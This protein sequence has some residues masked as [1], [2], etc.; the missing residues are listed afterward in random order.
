MRPPNRPDASAK[1][2]VHG[3]SERFIIEIVI[4]Q[5][6]QMFRPAS[7]KCRPCYSPAVSFGRNERHCDILNFFLQCFT[8]FYCEVVVSRNILNTRHPGLRCMREATWSS[9][10]DPWPWAASS[11][12]M[13]TSS[14]LDS[15]H[16]F[17]VVE[18]GWT[19]YLVEHFWM[20]WSVKPAVVGILIWFDDRILSVSQNR[21]GLTW[22]NPEWFMEWTW[23]LQMLDLPWITNWILFLQKVLARL[24]LPTTDTWANSWIAC[25]RPVKII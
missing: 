25:V 6:C 20:N 14:T 12:T 16:D 5:F 11:W 9:L 22:W 13:V 7:V 1:T 21:K 8:V 24:S 2:G 18:L 3:V 19:C 4:E 15:R 17:L 10:Q 23:W